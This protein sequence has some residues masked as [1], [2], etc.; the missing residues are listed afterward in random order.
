MLKT[1]LNNFLVLFN[2]GTT[3]RKIFQVSIS[4]STANS[5]VIFPGFNH[6]RHETLQLYLQSPLKICLMISLEENIPKWNEELHFQLNFFYICHLLRCG[7]WILKYFSFWTC[8][9]CKRLH[10]WWKLVWDNSLKNFCGGV[11]LSLWFTTEPGEC[12]M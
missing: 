1:S 7:I 6:T 8:G 12:N 9:D 5:Q 3:S 10:P 2:F 11:Q 4:N